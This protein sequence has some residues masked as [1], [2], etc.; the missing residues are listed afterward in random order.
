MSSKPVISTSVRE[1]I[2][3]V[4]RSGDLGGSG[5]FGG[6]NR[7]LEGT[8]GH[9]RLQ[10]KRPADYQTEV[11]VR[12]RTE[13]ENFIFE[14]KGRIDAVLDREGLLRVEEIKTVRRPWNGP[15]DP[16]HLAQAK[17]YAS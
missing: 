17:I 3:F 8:R 2:A 13:R 10:K 16:L 9:Q 12:W 7:A 6:R 15:P 4:L 5:G 11:P 1:L 14:L